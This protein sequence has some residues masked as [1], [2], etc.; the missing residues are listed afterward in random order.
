M[1][2]DTSAFGII[3]SHVAYSDLNTLS[4]YS[5][6]GSTAILLESSSIVLFHG[7]L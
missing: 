1:D 7:N 4:I 3:L 5:E 6:S 2:Q